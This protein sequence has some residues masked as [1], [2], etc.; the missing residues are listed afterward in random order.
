MTDLEDN[1]VSEKVVKS[2]GKLDTV[3]QRVPTWSR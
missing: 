1:L 3:L 2:E